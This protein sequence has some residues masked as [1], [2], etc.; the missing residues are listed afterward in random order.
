MNINIL[1]LLMEHGIDP[2]ERTT[3][4]TMV[5]DTALMWLEGRED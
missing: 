4:R 5:G 3:G 1:D 2:R